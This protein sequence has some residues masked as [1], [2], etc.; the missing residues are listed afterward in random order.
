MNVLMVGA[1]WIEAM[2]KTLESAGLVVQEHWTGRKPGDQRRGIPRDV[3]MVV[4]FYDR[5]NH[6]L[7]KKVRTDAARRGLPVLY[8]RHSLDDVQRKLE[9]WQQAQAA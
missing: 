4:V 6:C 7:A 2:R 8:C 3:E 1:D 9:A 5:V